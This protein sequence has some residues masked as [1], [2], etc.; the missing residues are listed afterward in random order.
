MGSLFRLLN[1]MI[2]SPRIQHQITI[3]REQLSLLY[4]SSLFCRLNELSKSSSFRCGLDFSIWCIFSD[5]LFDSIMIKINIKIP[6]YA[7]LFMIGLFRN[8]RVPNEGSKG[9]NQPPNGISRCNQ[10]SK[11]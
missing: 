11:Q 3:Y 8:P 4:F 10:D 1:L 5:L 9:V 2:V 6:I 7:H